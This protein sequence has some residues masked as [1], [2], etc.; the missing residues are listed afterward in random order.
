MS[1]SKPEYEAID[2]AHSKVELNQKIQLNSNDPEYLRDMLLKKAAEVGKLKNS[3]S[4]YEPIEVTL[5][6][7]DYWNI[8]V[9]KASDLIK[10]IKIAPWLFDM[11][12]QIVTI[13]QLFRSNTMGMVK[14]KR[15]WISTVVGFILGLGGFLFEYWMSG[16]VFTW[17]MIPTV[18]IPWV[19]GWFSKMA[20][21]KEETMRKA[22]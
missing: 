21:K 19:Y 13:I 17:S 9:A 3:L 15:W 11:A 6:V 16:G 20:P 22:A 2:P 18:I 4:K 5:G 8:V 12:I 14:D 7:D 10:I 1:E